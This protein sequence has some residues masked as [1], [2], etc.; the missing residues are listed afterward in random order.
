MPSGG[1]N[2]I[3]IVLLCVGMAADIASGGN[4]AQCIAMLDLTVIERLCAW[5]PGRESLLRV[6]LPIIHI[7]PHQEVSPTRAR[8][9]ASWGPSTD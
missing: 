1:V 8:V 5:Q 9:G 2:N 6:W 7:E 4:M 3:G